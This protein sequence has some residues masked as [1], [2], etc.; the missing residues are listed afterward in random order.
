MTVP[1]PKHVTGEQVRFAIMTARPGGL[2]KK[3]LVHV[4]DLTPS[5]VTNGIVWIREVAA[6]E[7]LTP[8]TYSRRHGYRFSDD[9]NDWA[10]YER[11]EM[12]RVLTTI[13]RTVKGTLDP[14][15]ARLPQ[16]SWADMVRGHTTAMI[17]SLEF[18]KRHKYEAV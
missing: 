9:P 13:L 14:H 1:L 17:S 18:I 2:H 11:S 8:L 5:Q 12:R 7:H 16:D 6:S 3:Q 15:L 10:D 4:T